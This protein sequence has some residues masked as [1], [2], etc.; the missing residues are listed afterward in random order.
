MLT[1][2]ST[3]SP[4]PISPSPI[5][6]APISPSPAPSDEGVTL[7]PA[8]AA[9]AALDAA[10]D[11]P[12]LTDTET[13][14]SDLLSTAFWNGVSDPFNSAIG[15]WAA[16]WQNV[17]P[18]TGEATAN[19]NFDGFVGRNVDPYTNMAPDG[20]NPNALTGGQNIDPY[21]GVQ[22]ADAFSGGGAPTQSPPP[23]V[24][25]N[26]GFGGLGYTG[27]GAAPASS[28]DLRLALNDAGPGNANVASDAVPNYGGFPPDSDTAADVGGSYNIRI[29]TIDDVQY[30]QT[31]D[32][33]GEV[34]YLWPVDPNAIGST[35]SPDPA[36]A[37]PAAASQPAQATPTATP[38]S[39]AAPP[40]P[41]D[42]ATTAPPVP[43]P[44]PPPDPPPL[45][46]ADPSQTQQSGQPSS[47]TVT[48]QPGSGSV[49]YDPMA[50]SPFAKLLLYGSSTPIRDFI[51]NDANLRVAQTAATLFA[52]LAAVVATGGLL[53]GGTAF[54]IGLG[55][56][57]AFGAGTGMTIA[58]ATG[59][60]TGVAAAAP[61]AAGAAGIVA[62]NPQ[63]PEE[64]EEAFENTLPG[65]GPQLQNSLQ[66]LA[67]R[68]ENTLPGLGPELQN[69]LQPLVETVAPEAESLAAKIGPGAR[70]F[71]DAAKLAGPGG[72]FMDDLG[73]LEKVVTSVN[74]SNQ[75]WQLATYEGQPVFGYVRGLTG[76]VDIQGVTQIVRLAYGAHELEV[77]EILGPFH[78]Q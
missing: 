7:G 70:I 25:P 64:I 30:Y 31:Q 8:D 20:A 16:D 5:S 65:L 15:G 34:S 29:V 59:V 62:Q 46:P 26:S 73:A 10:L 77:V 21:S 1:S 11:E 60:G 69:S 76:I 74:P 56:G 49:P 37:Q 14:A 51:T 54:G 2:S 33:P 41:S 23:S 36:P 24:D 6:P 32:L 39:A 72:S 3:S 12:I 57:S 68:F 19:G 61:L 58:G 22:D 63:L 50:D 17:D 9:T 47:P 52:D 48:P 53:A 38:S 28:P 35:Y 67:E 71:Q 4:T 75:I 55:T 40:S 45:P 43:T 44:S 66:P 27:P 18:Y 78:P 13:G 42:Q